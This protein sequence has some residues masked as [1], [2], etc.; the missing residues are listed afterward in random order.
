MKFLLKYS[1]LVIILLIASCDKECNVEG[2]C[3]LEPEIGPC[4]ALIPMYYFDQEKGKC[5]EFQWGGC[6]GVVPFDSLEECKL[7]KCE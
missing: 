3:A 4:E 5:K 1:S 6:E 7:C 2:N